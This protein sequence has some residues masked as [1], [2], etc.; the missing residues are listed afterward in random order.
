MG[1]WVGSATP[2][3]DA[4]CIT[5]PK[6]PISCTAKKHPGRGKKILREGELE[7]PY[8]AVNSSKVSSPCSLRRRAAV[9]KAAGAAGVRDAWTATAAGDHRTAA[10]RKSR[11][12]DDAVPRAA[13]RSREAVDMAEGG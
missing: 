3:P 2:D 12:D 9:L 7:C 8:L 1:R 11:V 6:L 13:A 5:Q 10:G 4:G